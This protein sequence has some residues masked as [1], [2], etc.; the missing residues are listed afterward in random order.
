MQDD[1]VLKVPLTTTA[2]FVLKGEH[3]CHECGCFVPVFAVMLVGPFHG[4]SALPL[5]AGDD[6]ALLRRPQELPAELAT[7]MT[8][9]SQGK[10][11]PDFSKTIAETYW[12]NHCHECDAKIGDWFVHKPGEAFFPTTDEEQA[13]LTGEL[14]AG[15]FTFMDPDIAVSSWTSAILRRAMNR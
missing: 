13:K 2:A 5:D 8:Q 14:V 12:M 15:P 10:F 11:R 4:E 3:A 7:A 1:D 6:S 9:A